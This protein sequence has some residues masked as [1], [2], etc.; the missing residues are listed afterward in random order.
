[1]ERG[2]AEDVGEVAGPSARPDI[3]PRQDLNDDPAEAAVLAAVLS[4]RSHRVLSAELGG[5][6]SV[7][8]REI[9]NPLR[10]ERPARP[11]PARASSSHSPTARKS[12]ACRSAPRGRARRLQRNRVDADAARAEPASTSSNGDQAGRVLAVGEHRDRLAAHLAPASPTGRTRGARRRWRCAERSRRSAGP[13]RR[14][15]RCVIRSSAAEALDAVVEATNAPRDRRAQRSHERQRRLVRDRHLVGHARAR[16][17]QQDQVDR[18]V[19]AAKNATCLTPSS[20]TAKSV[21]WSPATAFA[22]GP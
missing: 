6:L 1:M 5:D 16:I 22:P 13:D 17:E 9:L 10:K 15:E 12:P 20:N 4:A 2:G 18:H 21:S 8:T 3:R 7:D 19:L 11:S 14:L